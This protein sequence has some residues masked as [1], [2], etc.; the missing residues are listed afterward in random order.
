MLENLEFRDPWF[1]LVGLIAPVVFWLARKRR[2]ALIFSTLSVASLAPSGL[3]VRL[4]ALPALLYAVATLVL[5]V[6][7]AG[8]RTG[9]ATSLVQRDGISI[10][11]VVDRSGSMKIIDMDLEDSNSRL[12]VTREVVADFVRGRSADLVGLV[13]FDH[14]ASTLCPL[15]LDHANLVQIVEGLD[16][17]PIED[18]RG[19]TAIG[20]GIT[21]ACDRLRQ[22]EAKSKVIVLL[23]DGDSNAGVDPLAAAKFAKDLD[24]RVYTIG[25]GN[26]SGEAY[27]EVSNPRTGKKS[28]RRLNRREIARINPEVLSQIAED[29]GG[30]YFKATDREGLEEIY[31]EIDSLERSEVTELKYMEYHEHYSWWV[32]AGLGLV[33]VASLSS[34]TLLRRLP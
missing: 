14:Y 16:F 13:A 7:L 1:L 19:R 4:V 21:V 11:L 2:N 27:I 3:R 8:P 24:I 10:M 29:T 34:S 12:E 18:E 31:A 6:A 9:D 28:Y 32:V 17:S 23:T 33:A 26:E 25:L 22:Q 5:A 15:T 20:D 30:K